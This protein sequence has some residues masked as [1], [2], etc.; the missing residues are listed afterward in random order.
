M[1]KN[2]LKSLVAESKVY[3][4]LKSDFVVKALFKF[5]HETFLCF[6]MEYMIGGDFGQILEALGAL[7]ESVAK[8]YIAELIL[9]VEHLHTL[10]IVHRDLKPDN[11]LLDSNG[12]IKLTDF[13]LSEVGVSM[14]RNIQIKQE[15]KR[16]PYKELFD[17]INMTVKEKPALRVQYLE[18]KSSGMEIKFESKTPPISR[19]ELNQVSAVLLLIY[20]RV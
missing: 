12:H 2:K 4:V 10:G 1:N 19:K 16:K 11:I 7:D 3:E 17:T 15:S 6:V 8:F 20:G 13:G 9:A 5:T 18:K 14:V